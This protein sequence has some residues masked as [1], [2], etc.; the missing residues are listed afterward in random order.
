MPHWHGPSYGLYV[1]TALAKHDRGV[2][3]VP[4]QLAV[5]DRAKMLEVPMNFWTKAA[6]YPPVLWHIICSRAHGPARPTSSQ[7]T[8]LSTR[9]LIYTSRLDRDQGTVMRHTNVTRA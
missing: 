5:S 8:H 3:V 2:H 7:Q 9:P 6:Q 4:L 1:R